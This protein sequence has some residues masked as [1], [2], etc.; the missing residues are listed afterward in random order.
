VASSGSTADSGHG[1]DLF[2]F[3]EDGCYPL[4]NLTN[5][6]WTVLSL[7]PNARRPHDARAFM[8]VSFPWSTLATLGKRSPETELVVSADEHPTG[9]HHLC[10]SWRIWRDRSGNNRSSGHAHRQ[11]VYRLFSVSI[12]RNSAEFFAIEGLAF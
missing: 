10:S 11:R 8:L 7:V 4:L 12:C 3:P 6:T 9:I 2:V 5:E 1:R